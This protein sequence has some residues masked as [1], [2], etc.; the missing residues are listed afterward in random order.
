MNRALE[1]DQLFLSAIP[2]VMSSGRQMIQVEAFLTE[3]CHGKPKDCDLARFM[4]KME[5]MADGDDDRTYS[6]DDIRVAMD[7]LKKEVRYPCLHHQVPT[8]S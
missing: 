3:L 1:L 5:K 2:I 6:L 7:Q 4:N 8:L